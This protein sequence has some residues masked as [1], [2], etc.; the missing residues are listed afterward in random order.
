MTTGTL[1]P[2]QKTKLNRKHYLDFNG[3]KGGG[4]DRMIL[5][6]CYIQ[7]LRFML[8]VFA[9]LFLALKE[10]GDGSVFER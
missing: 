5:K 4:A 6:S 1:T 9:F 8:L 10:F 2:W 3:E 7:H